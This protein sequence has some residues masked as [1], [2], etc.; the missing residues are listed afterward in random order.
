MQKKSGEQVPQEKKKG[1]KPFVELVESAGL[2]Q[3]G[4]L[5]AIRLKE[6]PVPEERSLFFE[7]VEQLAEKWRL[8]KP[9]ITFTTKEIQLLFD[10][11]ISLLSSFVEELKLF[12]FPH[13]ENGI[14]ID[15]QI[16]AL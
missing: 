6:N 11:G 4:L 2:S 1:K 15:N 5:L 7:L 13:G 12:L 10:Q 8:I 14:V 9:A 16:T 3:D